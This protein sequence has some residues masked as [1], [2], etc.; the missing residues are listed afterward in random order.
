MEL[1]DESEAGKFRVSYRAMVMRK[2]GSSIAPGTLS[3]EYQAPF[4]IAGKERHKADH[5]S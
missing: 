4:D 1:M 2:L 5:P 3:N